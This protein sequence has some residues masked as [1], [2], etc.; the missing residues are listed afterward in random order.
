MR[1]AGN[2]AR[3]HPFVLISLLAA[4]AAGMLA[5]AI[6]ARD[7]GNRG[8]RV[9]AATL[10]CTVVW[11][12][13][14][15]F[16]GISGDPESALL[17]LRSSCIG[18]VM[19][20]A[21]A[22]HMLITV[23]PSLERRYGRYLP[24]VYGVA[25][26]FV[27]IALA[28]PAFWSGVVRTDWGWSGEIGFGV[29]I[30]WAVII[31]IPAAALIEWFR[32][33]DDTATMDTWMGLAVA[34]PAFAATL[35]D[36]VLPFAGV[37]FPHLGSASL[38][39]WGGLA[40]WKVYR[41]RDPILAP[42]L[43]A[44]EILATLPDGVTLLRLD[45]TIRSANRKMAELVGADASELA[46]LPID[47]IL[48]D[49]EAP[50]S[51]VHGDHERRLVRTTGEQIAVLVYEQRLLDDGGDR[52]GKVLVVRDLREVASLRNRLVTSGRLAAVG[53]LAAGIAHEINNPI[54]YVQSN[55]N[56]LE[57]HWQAAQSA[58]AKQEQGAP[59][60]A[61]CAEGMEMIE[62]S[63]EGLAR[64]ASIV[65]DV[66]GFSRDSSPAPESCDLNKLLDT[67]ARVAEPQL[68][69]RAR[70][71]RHYGELPLVRCIGQELMQVF[72]NL[73]LN[74]AHATEPMGEIVIE[75]EADDGWVEV[76]LRD[77]GRGMDAETREQIFAP[78]FTTKPVGEGTG[79][80]LPI[81]LQIVEKHGGTI[82]VD[83][84][85]EVGTTFRVRVPVGNAE[86]SAGGEA[87]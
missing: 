85:P 76:R 62:E 50:R 21:L 69:H 79:L 2:R 86:E 31:P 15:F 26:T 42:H 19:I 61:T 34:I 38:V 72:L 9:A 52:L 8:N 4:L 58:F 65:R 54:A 41:F 81:S 60:E 68:R 87:T 70:V 73:L 27:F 37:R 75:T 23:E 77:D 80:G 16:S 74:A 24:F 66:G 36:F 14:E 71:E 6:L 57:E 1:N 40:L 67:A 25:V 22:L 64:V 49:L 32:S 55:I 33:R 20:G 5:A 18:S 11:S 17:F 63:R 30:S 51:R 44:R 43:F 59:V 45:G 56:V 83:S 3:M 10:G 39:T 48:I 84:T 47:E 46:G 35:T 29:A 13:G 53:Q 82:D 7:P 78:F 12:L 28:T